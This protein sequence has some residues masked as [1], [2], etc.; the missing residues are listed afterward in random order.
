[1]AVTLPQAALLSQDPLQRG[2][3]ETFVQSSPILDRIP[4]MDI[5]GNSYRYNSEGTLPGVSFRGVNE[6]YVEST[7]TVNQASEGLV[8]LGGDADVDTFIQKTRSDLNDQR[9]VQTAMKVKAASYKYQDA[10]FNG[11][12]T[13]EPKGFDGLKKR[14]VGGQVI[15]AATNGMDIVAAGH[16]FLDALDA[17]LALTDADVIYGNKKVIGKVNSVLDH[18]GRHGQA[19]PDVQRDPD[20][21]PRQDRGRRRHPA[22]DRD[23]RHGVRHGLALRREVRRGRGR[24]RRDRPHQRRR[25]RP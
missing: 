19:C 8:I 1:M 25:V 6:A 20:P 23:R 17:L 22:A 13:V 14:L 2:V 16:D 18:R 15:D 4:F 3:I 21:R 12:V 7:G 11:D 10:F 24:R 5:E 9:A